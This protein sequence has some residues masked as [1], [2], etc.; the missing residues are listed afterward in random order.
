M[1][2]LPDDLRSAFKDPLGPVYTSP[3]TLLT[4]AGEPL[5]TVGDVVTFHLRES[6]YD[7]AVAV[8]DGRTKRERVTPEIA[9]ALAD[10]DRVTWQVENPPGTLTEALLDAVR[11]ALA[12]DFPAVIRVEGEEDLAALPAIVATPIGGSVVYGQPDE[13]MVLVNVTP[14]AK[15]KARS[16]MDRMRGDTTAALALLE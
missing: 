4:D 7:P 9:A 12:A 15:A 14:E 2:Q 10:I 11:E 1:L 16:L 3:E 8:I 6:G 5:V 13:G